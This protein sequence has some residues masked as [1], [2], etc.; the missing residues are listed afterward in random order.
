M[1]IY[2]YYNSKK[3]TYVKSGVSN[4]VYLLKSICYLS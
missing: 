3:K 2:V 4:V 1:N